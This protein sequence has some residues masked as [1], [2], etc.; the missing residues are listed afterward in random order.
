MTH[1]VGRDEQ[2]GGR[3]ATESRRSVVAARGDALARAKTGSE[4]WVEQVLGELR[5]ARF[6]PRA[7]VRFLAASFVQARRTRRERRREH[8]TVLLLAVAGV[9][10]WAAVAAFGRPSLAA[11]GAGWW[12]LVLLMLDW[13]LGMLERPDG[14]PLGGLGIANLL[15]LVRASVVPVLPALPP[16]ALGTVILAASATDVADGYLARRRDECTRLG[17]WLDAAVDGFMVTVAA[18]AAARHDRLPAWLAVLV[19]ARYLLPWLV[20]G[21]AYFA[22]ATAPSRSGYVSGRV[23]GVVL[24]IGLSGAAFA[25]PGAEVLVVAGVVGGLAT[26]GATVGRSLRSR[27]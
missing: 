19:V 18:V 7:W 6:T 16:L 2:D 24:V 25:L 15:S 8:R 22:N 20:I 5:A 27:D 4:L 26:F 11:I 3:E 14:R 10:S 21:T 12:L 23:P 1:A 13:H 9:A 17:V